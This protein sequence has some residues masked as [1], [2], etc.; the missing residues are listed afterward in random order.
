[1][2]QEFY[3][4]EISRVHSLNIFAEKQLEILSSFALENSLGFS[5]EFPTSI[6]FSISIRDSSNDLK[7]NFS[8]MFEGIFAE[9]PT[10]SHSWI[11]LGFLSKYRTR[12]LRGFNLAILKEFSWDSFRNTSRNSF[13]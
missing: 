8:D 12:L 5:Q 13:K 1:M 6:P 9:I 7:N 3:I 10:E 11:P 2:S 4:S